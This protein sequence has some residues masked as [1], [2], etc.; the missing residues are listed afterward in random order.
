MTCHAYDRGSYLFLKNLTWFRMKLIGQK[1]GGSEY[2]AQHRGILKCEFHKQDMQRRRIRNLFFQNFILGS[3]LVLAVFTREVQG[4]RSGKNDIL[5]QL[6]NRDLV[7]SDV[8]W[9]GPAQFWSKQ[10]KP[11][12]SSNT[13]IGQDWNIKVTGKACWKCM[14][15]L[16]CKFML[17]FASD[18]YFDRA[19]SD[20]REFMVILSGPAVVHG[21]I[22]PNPKSPD[23]L[24]SSFTVHYQTWDTG[25]YLLTIDAD[26][27]LGRGSGGPQSNRLLQLRIKVERPSRKLPKQPAGPCSIGLVGRW[28]DTQMAKNGTEFIPKRERNG[29]GRHLLSLGSTYHGV[30]IPPPP[31]RPYLQFQTY[32][33]AGK[34]QPLETFAN[35]LLQKG[36][37]EVSIVG[38]SHQRA[39]LT[40]LQTL[41]DGNF[42][43]QYHGDR[44]WYVHDDITGE[45]LRIN[46]YWMEGIFRTG[47]FGCLRP[48]LGEPK[49]PKFSNTSDIVILDAGAWTFRF[50][51]N[52]VA[53]Y[54][55]YLPRFMNWAVRRPHKETTR[56]FWRTAPPFPNKW[57]GCSGFVGDRR[58]SM[59]AKANDI[60]RRISRIYG[61]GWMNFWPIEAPRYG[62]ACLREVQPGVWKKDSHYSCLYANDSKV[63]GIVGETVAR[64]FVHMLVNLPPT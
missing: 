16:P 9:D 60:A 14:A 23:S 47:K 39:L 27:S 59:F 19:I 37:R 28:V 29:Y 42:S 63:H 40:H 44:L 32:T 55:Y 56:F 3:L 2:G 11:S 49:W 1:V 51:R 25:T 33:C 12:Q 4:M 13:T 53:A 22:S 20:R 61:I 45:S 41:V 5:Q 58:S 6:A 36:I 54:N 7:S 26:C 38:D 34:M 46:F 18:V 48:T 24:G 57:Y 30:G 43:G 8:C 50:C 35:A 52:A 64:V 62:D 21:S 10:G 17:N 31:S 15:G